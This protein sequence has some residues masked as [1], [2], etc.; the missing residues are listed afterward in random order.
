MIICAS[1]IEVVEANKRASSNKSLKVPKERERPESGLQRSN[2]AILTSI[3]LST[4]PFP[5]VPSFRFSPS[6]LHTLDSALHE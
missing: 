2:N 6:L 5:L 1:R 3:S 4:F